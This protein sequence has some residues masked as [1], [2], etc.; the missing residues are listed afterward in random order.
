MGWHLKAGGHLPSLSRTEPSK[1]IQDLA[2]VHKSF[3]TDLA[4]LSQVQ[5][6]GNS[7]PIHAHKCQ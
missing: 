6:E 5:E 7:G 2:D 3:S 1:A 4:G